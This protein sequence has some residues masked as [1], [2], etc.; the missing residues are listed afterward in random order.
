MQR[1]RSNRTNGKVKE[2]IAM[3]KKKNTLIKGQLLN[4]ASLRLKS[5][6]SG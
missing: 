1:E 3:E 6:T 2:K 4:N 5:M